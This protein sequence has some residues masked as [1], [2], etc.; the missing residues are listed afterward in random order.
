MPT[1]K[2]L[3]F[4]LILALGAFAAQGASAQRPGG[5]PN[6]QAPAGQ[7]PAA[8]AG[9]G[10]RGQQPPQGPRPYAEVITSK[11]VSD[12]GVF[13]THRIGEQL[14]YE[15]PKAMLGRDFLLKV[16]QAGTVPGVGFAGEQ[17]TERV[18]RWERLQD[19]V[20]FRMVSFTTQADS[21]LPVDRAVT[22]SN[23]PAILM[24]FAIA[25]FSPT[26][27]NLVIDGSPLYTTDVQELNQR[28][29]FRSRRMDP[30]RSMITRVQT[31]PTNVEVSTLSTFEVDS[32]PGAGGGFFGGGGST[33]TITMRL[34]YSMVLLPA[35]PMQPRLCDNRIGFFSV[36]FTDYGA[37][38]PRVPQRCYI[39]RWRLVKKDPTAA[40]SDVVKPIIYYIDPA[41]PAKYVPWLIRAVM[42]S[43]QGLLR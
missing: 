20:L 21:S 42:Y 38:K 39:S 8:Q 33:N 30:A 5:P 19:R 2:T 3:S 17:V 13:I 14:Y 11:A 40:V 35:D 34:H 16:S 9:G 7:A 36:E 22:L 23:Q 6:P 4:S 27:S 37:D 12:T 24:S 43:R 18:V 15:I 28:Q 32:V 26:D 1:R 25:A 10:V 31:F 41:T 29:R